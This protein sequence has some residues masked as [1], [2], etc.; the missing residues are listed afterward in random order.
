MSVS[1]RPVPPATPSQCGG[2]RVVTTAPTFRG[3]CLPTGN[4]I[5][6]RVLGGREAMK[7]E[8]SGDQ[9]LSGIQTFWTVLGTAHGDSPDASAAAQQLLQR[10]TKAVNRYLLGAL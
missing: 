10:Y 5:T 2:S 6:M 7:K 8:S 1:G 3:S 9:R 4:R